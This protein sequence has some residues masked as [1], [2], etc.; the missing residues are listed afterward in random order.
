MG[1]R[2]N[3]FIRKFSSNCV[4]FT[5]ADVNATKAVCHTFLLKVQLMEAF[6]NIVLSFVRAV[7]SP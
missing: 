7:D 4:V 6:I 1:A 5:L 2:T 3:G